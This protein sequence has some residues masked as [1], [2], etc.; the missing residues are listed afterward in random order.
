MGNRLCSQCDKQFPE[1]LLSGRLRNYPVGPGEIDPKSAAAIVAF[2]N[3]TTAVTTA[4]AALVLSTSMVDNLPAN[5]TATANG[6]GAAKGAA[7]TQLPKGTSHKRERD[8]FVENIGQRIS[9]R[10]RYVSDGKKVPQF[11]SDNIHR[12]ETELVA[13][14]KKC[15]GQLHQNDRRP[16]CHLCGSGHDG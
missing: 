15:R 10:D 9:H 8:T 7:K 14:D 1:H 13:H 2:G 12:F 6:K 5:S 3:T 16:H 4:A 11:L